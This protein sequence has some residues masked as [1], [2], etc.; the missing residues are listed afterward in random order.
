L[1]F[2]LETNLNFARRVVIPNFLMSESKLD[3]K[4]G[5]GGRRM[6]SGAFAIWLCG[7]SA[8]ALLMTRFS[9]IPGPDTNAPAHWPAQSAIV[10]SRTNSTL[11]MFAHPH[12]TC[13][14]A[15]VS[16]LERLMARTQGQINAHV[17]F[18]KPAELPANWTDTALW[19]RASGIP[20]VTV[21]IDTEG[22]EARRF[23][24]AMSG[25]TMVYGA[26]GHLVFHGGITIS[27]GHEGDNHGLSAIV[28]LS[29]TH[30]VRIA[31]TPVFGCSLFANACPEK[32]P[33]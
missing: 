6:W 31:Q 21:H 16:E 13:T 11:V 5:G 25:E 32:G 9:G 27:R 12:C 10:L 18:L 15:S 2:R 33:R 7:V 14:E 28:A 30:P 19:R 26:D 8:G 24:S 4:T 29:K 22:A 3:N 23:G 20:G 17:L 1:G